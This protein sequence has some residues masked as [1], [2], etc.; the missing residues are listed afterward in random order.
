MKRSNRLVLLVGVFLA[1]LAFVGII[2]II[3][4][5]SGPGSGPKV[6]EDAPTVYAAK[7][8][9]LGSEIT[10]DMLVAQ[11]TKLTE[12]DP[13]AFSSPTLLLGKIAAKDIPQG[14]QLTADDFNRG[15]GITQVSV[16]AGMRAIAVQVDQVSGVGTVI[17]T[18]DYVDLLVGI[19]GDKFPVI[20]AGTTSNTFTVVSG[21]NA[22]SAKLLLQGMQVVGTLLPP[23]TA[24]ATGQAASPAP[25]GNEPATNLNGQQEIVILA[26]APS[27]PRSSSSPRWTARSRWSSARRRT[28]ATTR[29]TPSSRRP[30][31]P[32]A[33]PSRSSSTSTGSS[34]RSSSRPPSPHRR[35]RTDKPTRRPSRRHR[36]G[37]PRA[38]WASPVPR[39][40]ALRGHPSIA[41]TSRRNEHR[42]MAD[43][44]RVLIV[45]DIPETRD[46]LTKLLGFE[47]DIEV[48]GSAASGA[49]A[50]DLATRLAPDVVL[51]DINMPDMD[52]ISGDRADGGP[53]PRRP[54]S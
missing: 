20:T 36:R 42:Q 48:V 50:L 52:G 45:D 39:P 41:Q 1:I 27:R 43:Q 22:T 9:A 38:R 2:V 21:I 32:P 47:T 28:S 29:A 7:P 17:R 16:P 35:S 54:S 30:P 34:S 15:A 49:E 6:A 25:G 24:A 31:A 40:S 8:I 4:G 51:M 11:T 44:I 10:A 3:Q 46:H 23:P 19:T 33:S 14:K 12:R 5:N 13:S 53:C 37:R 18:G 26:V